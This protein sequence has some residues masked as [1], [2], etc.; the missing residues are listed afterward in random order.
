MKVERG[1]KKKQ[2]E[3]DRKRTEK[4]KTREQGRGGQCDDVLEDFYMMQQRYVS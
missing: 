2:S 4:K 3:S 1:E